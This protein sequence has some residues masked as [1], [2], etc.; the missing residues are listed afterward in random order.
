MSPC[1]LSKRPPRY[2]AQL[3]HPPLHPQGFPTKPQ[4]WMEDAREVSLLL[5][6]AR[7]PRQTMAHAC[8]TLG[9]PPTAIRTPP[10][11]LPLATLTLRPSIRASR[12]A[13]GIARTAPR[14]HGVERGVMA[15]Q[16]PVHKPRSER[17]VLQGRDPGR[18]TND[19]GVAQADGPSTTDPKESFRL[20]PTRAVTPADIPRKP[21][22][23]TWRDSLG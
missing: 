23:E 6:I 17:R 16:K 21:H 8:G 9:A 20:S 13:R 2:T 14:A 11:S 3:Q 18:T 19:Q 12:V 22:R 1:I 4:P 5:P 10:G 15:K 7:P